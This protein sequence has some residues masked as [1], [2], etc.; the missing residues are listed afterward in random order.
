MLSGFRGDP[1]KF[2][3]IPKAQDERPV[4]AVKEIID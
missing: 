4:V 3:S 2:L 1:L